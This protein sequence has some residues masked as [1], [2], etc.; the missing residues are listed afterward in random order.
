MYCLCILLLDA[1]ADLQYVALNLLPHNTQRFFVTSSRLEC[2]C[3]QVGVLHQR[4]TGRG[5]H[6]LEQRIHLVVQ[7]N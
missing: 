2:R 5:A 3:V 4:E 1:A 6:L 7:L